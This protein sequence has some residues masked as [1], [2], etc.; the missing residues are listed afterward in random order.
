LSFEPA[1]VFE[2]SNR[3]NSGAWRKM[4]VLVVGD[5]K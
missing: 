2:F 1:N 4:V 5:V 3:A